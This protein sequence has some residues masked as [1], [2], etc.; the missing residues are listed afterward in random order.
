MLRLYATGGR[1]FHIE[2]PWEL[3]L[4]K[5]PKAG[6]QRLPQ[7]YREMAFEL[8][9]DTLDLRVYSARKGRMW[10]TANVARENGKFKVAISFDEALAITVEDYGTLCSAPR[11]APTPTPPALCQRLAVLYAKAESKIEG[12]AKRKKGAKKDFELLAR[13]K[14]EFPPTL[15]RLLAGEGV[16]ETAGFHQI[17]MQVAITANAL[18]KT[19]A[20]VLEAATGLIENHVSDG[21]RQHPG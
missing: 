13:F 3:F 8:F 18:G 4:P 17:A 2:V 12:A 5:P 9:V 1:G 15:Q 20:Y 16:A 7:I 10:R 19:D 14:G 21:H 11:P 6:V